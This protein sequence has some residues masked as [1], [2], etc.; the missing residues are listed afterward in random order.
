MASCNCCTRWSCTALAVVASV[1]VGVIAAFLR[2]SAVITVT[3]AF[4]WVT[5]G[6]A[7][8]Y[9][10]VT[11]LATAIAR[12]EATPC[13]C[14]AL[15]TQLLGILGTVLFSVILLAVTFAATSLIGA[16]FV[17]VLLFFFSLTV[18]STACV[19]KCLADCHN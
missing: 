19:V 2:F 10:G 12:K 13:C 8:G 16:V 5:L 6:V 9:L 18:T 15:S 11:L 3:P 4:L 17:G 1:A 7:I 14:A